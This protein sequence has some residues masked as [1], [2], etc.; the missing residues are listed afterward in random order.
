MRKKIVI[1]IMAIMGF[2]GMF[3]K[4][5]CQ[6]EEGEN[7]GFSVV[8]GDEAP[9]F[10]IQYLDGTEVNL[11]DLRGKVVMLQFTASWCKVCRKEMPYIEKEIWQMFKDNK[12]FVLVAI[13]LK[14]EKEKVEKFLSTQRITYPISL[15]P[16]GEIFKLYTEPNAGVT[17]NVLVDR[18]GRIAFLT[19]LFDEE[20]LERLKV[21]IAELLQ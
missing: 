12:D 21:Q 19:R 11:S 2:S 6:S 3:H 14:E 5:Q 10:T 8:I 13:D 4:A 15:D 20:E 1:A 17:R 18:D 9:E 7:R 16:K